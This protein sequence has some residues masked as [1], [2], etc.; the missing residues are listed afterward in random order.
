MASRK[1][2][3]YTVDLN[4]MKKTKM[5][6]FSLEGDKVKSK[7]SNKLF[8]KEMTKEGIYT[9]KGTFKPE[10]GKDFMDALEKAYTRSSTIVVE[11]A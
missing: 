5:A 6:E 9:P 4:D 8:E 7:F 10:D 2:T 3:V 1:L 11:R